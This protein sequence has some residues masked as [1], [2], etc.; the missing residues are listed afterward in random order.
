MH[1]RTLMIALLF[2]ACSCERD[3]RPLP[4]AAA[5]V[6]S[7]SA[8]VPSARSSAPPVPSAAA[9]ARNAE[10]K[11]VGTIAEWQPGPNPA[12]VLTVDGEKTLLSGVDGA[13][14]G[15]RIGDEVVVEGVSPRAPDR[16][17]DCT[18]ASRCSVGL[19]SGGDVLLRSVDGHVAAQLLPSF[20]VNVTLGGETR[21]ASL[22]LR[23][24]TPD[25][26]ARA[27]AAAF[28][29][30]MRRHRRI[31]LLAPPSHLAAIKL[32]RVPHK[33]HGIDLRLVGAELNDLARLF[34]DVGRTTM[35]GTLTGRVTLA[36]RE[37][38]S[39]DA[40][41]AWFALCGVE[42]RPTGVSKL[43]LTQSG[44]VCGLPAFP[45]PRC[46]PPEALDRTRDLIGTLHCV[47]PDQLRVMAVVD[48]A[49]HT[50]SAILGVGDPRGNTIL[51]WEGAYLAQSEVVHTDGG[52]VEINWK[53][54][55]I[56]KAG[57]ELVWD[58][59]YAGVPAKRLSVPA[60]TR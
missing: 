10:P 60:S 19:K 16:T 48:S 13:S 36:A 38:A 20:G 23:A 49:S 45:P 50:R 22:E 14:L 17:L 55:K 3:T 24:T 53:V 32:V 18:D 54:D 8:E 37:V 11:T 12:V 35:S 1:I 52:D 39:A 5:D 43:E 4:A 2:S 40:L 7:P 27:F 28:G 57:V 25:V 58:G 6:S 56:G 15:W 41:D 33:S 30:G 46:R 31:T 26:F 47:P 29:L 34:G 44:G 59:A 42:A 9:P 21:I 51:V